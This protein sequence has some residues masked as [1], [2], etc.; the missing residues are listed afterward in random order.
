MWFVAYVCGVTSA[1]CDWWTGISG[2]PTFA[3]VIQRL[4]NASL[5]QWSELT[6]E[7]MCTLYLSAMLIHNGHKDKQKKSSAYHAGSP[8]PLLFCLLNRNTSQM[9]VWSSTWHQKW[10]NQSL[11][12]PGS[13]ILGQ[14]PEPQTNPKYCVVSV[15]LCLNGLKSLFSRW[16]IYWVANVAIYGFYQV[17]M[18]C[19]F[20]NLVII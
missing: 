10:F 6:V 8:P 13:G 20:N 5:A 3:A 17:W 9:A 4:M 12:P 16:T 1:A 11:Q 7:A 18:K 15:W 14:D 2:L 19:V